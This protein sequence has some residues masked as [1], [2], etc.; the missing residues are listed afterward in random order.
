[1]VLLARAHRHLEAQLQTSA[2]R[3]AR[4]AKQLVEAN[5]EGAEAASVATA[6]IEALERRLREGEARLKA[7]LEQGEALRVRAEEACKLGRAETERADAAR[8]RADDEHERAERE[9]ERAVRERERAE[10][11]RERAEGAEERVRMLEAERNTAKHEREA[12]AQ[13]AAARE[14]GL[15]SDAQLAERERAAAMGL[16]DEMRRALEDSREA[17]ARAVAMLRVRDDAAHEQAE[18]AAAA[19][20]LL[21]AH[22]AR[23]SELEGTLAAKEREIA[24]CNTQ[25]QRTLAIG[26]QLE[27]IQ[28]LIGE[29]GASE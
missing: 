23:I 2:E 6:R 15:I 18:A 19:A 24:R 8:A 17:E 22:A 7:V 16:A 12:A 3:E 29:L 20:T 28:A 13:A 26:A 21:D 1:M 11:E 25:L 9:R 5:T 27:S 10:R 14:A 4:L